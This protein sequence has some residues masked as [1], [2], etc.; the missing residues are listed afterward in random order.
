M[1]NHHVQITTSHIS[2]GVLCLSRP[3]SDT[4]K[5]LYAIATHLYHPARGNPAA[6]V[7]WSDVKDSNG[8]KLFQ[9]IPDAFGALYRS[10]GLENPK[11]GNLIYIYTWG[12]DHTAF[13][14]WYVEERV[15]RAKQF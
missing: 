15:L 13:R 3:D 11:T 5:V 8:E 14:K 1:D 7:L 12:I 2:C 4:N 9:A 10:T 6:F